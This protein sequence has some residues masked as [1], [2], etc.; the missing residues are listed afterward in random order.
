MAVIEA[1]IVVGAVMVVVVLRRDC[2]RVVLVVM[3]VANAVAADARAAC[4][5]QWQQR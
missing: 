2:D 3:L 4:K 5:Q 1:V